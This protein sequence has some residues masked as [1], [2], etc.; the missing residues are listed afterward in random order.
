LEYLRN[1]FWGDPNGE[2]G[3]PPVVSLLSPESGSAYD[4][5]ATITINVTASSSVATITQVEFF[6]GT[7]LLATFSEASYEYTWT[8]VPAGNYSITAKATDSN[9]FD[10]FNCKCL[11]KWRC[12]RGFNIF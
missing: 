7:T 4:D 11:G 1:R 5:P 8:D 6:S 9:P 2:E 3:V 12:H 10:F